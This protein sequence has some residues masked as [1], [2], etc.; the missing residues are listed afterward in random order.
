MEIF[1]VRND[2]F[3][4]L[5]E[6]VVENEFFT[7]STGMDYKEAIRESFK[8]NPESFFI[9]AAMDEEDEQIVAFSISSIPAQARNGFIEYLYYLPDYANTGQKMFDLTREWMKRKGRNRIQTTTDRVDG[10]LLDNNSFQTLSVIV[11]EDI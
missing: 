11:G 6:D 2:E 10:E 7:E 5:I 3:F 8:I 4:D 9:L 1:R